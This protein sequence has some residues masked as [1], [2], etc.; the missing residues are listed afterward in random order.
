MRL[1]GI[2]NFF[3]FTGINPLFGKTAGTADM[4]VHADRRKDRAAD[5]NIVARSIGA[6]IS[7]HDQNIISAAFR[8]FLRIFHLIPPSSGQPSQPLPVFLPQIS[9][10]RVRI[11]TELIS[12]IIV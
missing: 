10:H 11:D 3:D 12:L 7:V 6:R 8:A 4:A 9:Q 1:P 5:H 2:F